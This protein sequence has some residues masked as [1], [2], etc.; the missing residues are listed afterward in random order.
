MTGSLGRDGPRPP[1]DWP[2]PPVLG[3]P[4]LVLGLLLGWPLLLYW[5]LLLGWPLLSLGWPLPVLGWPLL[6]AGRATAF[7]LAL[8]TGF[9]HLTPP[10]MIVPAYHCRTNGA[11]VAR[12]CPTFRHSV[13]PILVRRAS[14][15]CTCPKIEYLGLVALIASSSAVLPFSSRRATVS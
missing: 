7:R 11:P 5:A 2:L 15:W 4:L 1:P 9:R 10:T 13:T 12:K 14:G 3:W 8:S 6:F